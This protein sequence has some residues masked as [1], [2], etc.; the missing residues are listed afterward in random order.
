MLKLARVFK[1]ILIFAALLALL[2]VTISWLA[3][4]HDNHTQSAQQY[5]YYEA[6]RPFGGPFFSTLRWFNGLYSSEGIIAAFTVVLAIS[7]IALWDA[8]QQSA[9][10]AERAL[11]EHERPWLFLDAVKIERRDH[12]G[13]SP[14]PNNYFV[15]LRWKNIGRSPA[16]IHNCG[17]V[18]ED[19]TKLAENPDYSRCSPL[20]APRTVA[21]GEN[22]ETNP[23][24][25]VP[26]PKNTQE[27]AMWGRVTYAELGGRKH[28]SGYA[29]R[30]S[31]H[32]DASV[33]VGWDSY[34]YYD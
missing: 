12:E 30:I 34:D 16:V 2:D 19:Y 25:P 24:G 6:C 1:L 4:C 20:G 3:T 21:V 13:R 17:F 10:I 31:P 15:T 26:G 22:F 33:A 7:T 23:V 28:N 27:L 29:I 18:F 32:T 11:S 5:S 14:I 9:K 8:T